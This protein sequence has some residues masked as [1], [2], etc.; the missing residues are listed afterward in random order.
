[1]KKKQTHKIMYGFY[2]RCDDE[3]MEAFFSREDIAE[4]RLETFL[5]KSDIYEEDDIE[6]RHTAYD[7]RWDSIR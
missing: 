3:F 2:N 4:K 5:K 7:G 6:I 1:M